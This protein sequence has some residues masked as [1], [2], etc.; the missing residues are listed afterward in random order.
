MA[1][2][3]FGSKDGAGKGRGIRPGALRRNRNTGSCSRGGS[4]YSRGAGR[5]KGQGRS[6]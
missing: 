3:R 1:T 2:R 5:G 4:G 6:G